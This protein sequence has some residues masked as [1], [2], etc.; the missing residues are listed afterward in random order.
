MCK[1]EKIF[2]TCFVNDSY[3]YIYFQ[4]EWKALQRQTFITSEVTHQVE[5]TFCLAA[6]TYI[7]WVLVAYCFVL[8][9]NFLRI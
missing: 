7:V 2:S 5:L 1:M 3:L 6:N 8:S 4:P 9:G